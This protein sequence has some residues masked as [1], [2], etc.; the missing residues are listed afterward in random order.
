MRVKRRRQ[1]ERAAFARLEA[2]EAADRAALLRA[3][4]RLAGQQEHVPV[5]VAGAPA[6][7]SPALVPRQRP[8]NQR[9]QRG[10]AL[11]LSDFH[12]AFE[13]H[14]GLPPDACR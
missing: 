14:G 12:R 6:V 13:E 1:R 11:Q 10:L 3:Y 9:R 5:E 8:V 4:P 2:A 7:A